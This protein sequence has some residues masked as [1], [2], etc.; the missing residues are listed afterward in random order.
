MTELNLRKATAIAVG[1]LGLLAYW[2]AVDNPFIADDYALLLGAEKAAGHCTA[3]FEMP[4]GWRR[5]VSNFFFTA[6]F[7]LFGPTSFLF[8][9]ANLFL[10]VVNS[11]L[12]VHLVRGVTG[13]WRA[14]VG[15]G[16]FFAVFERPQEPGF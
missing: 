8:Y 12:V 14:A 13:S 5:L 9:Q 10:H 15:G 1:V 6:C 7:A 11:L 16:P 4:L 2:P 3:L